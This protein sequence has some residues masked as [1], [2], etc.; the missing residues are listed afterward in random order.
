VNDEKEFIRK[1]SSHVP[2]FL[3]ASAFENNPGEGVSF[4]LD[5]SERNCATEQIQTSRIPAVKQTLHQGSNS[6]FKIWKI[7]A[8][9]IL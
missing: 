3:G 6:Q 5:L 4:F 7:A 1:D 9:Q 8:H 2:I